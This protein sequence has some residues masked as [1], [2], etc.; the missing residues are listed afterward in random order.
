MANFILEKVNKSVID[1]RKH[2]KVSL[3]R[4]PIF[5]GAI[6]HSK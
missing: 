3:Q 6:R 4:I 5:T 2:I 1:D